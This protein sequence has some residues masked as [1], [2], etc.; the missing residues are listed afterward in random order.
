MRL[1]T[2]YVFGLVL[3]AIIIA[4]AGGLF[5]F[6]EVKN[7]SRFIVE[8]ENAQVVADLVQVGPLTAGRIKVMNVDVG[9]P[10][11]EGQAIAIVEVS[12]TITRSGTTDTEQIG[13]RGVQDLQVEVLAPISGVI[14][15]RWAKIGDIVP[16]G[17]RIVT[18]MDPRQVW[19]EANIE[20]DEIEDVRPGQTVEIEVETLER[21]LLGRV[22]SVSPVTTATL[23]TT[24]GGA[25]A[26]DFK[27]VKRV[28]QIKITIDA[29]QPPLIPGTS[30]EIKVLTP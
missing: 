5:A 6:S 1:R 27:S 9:S 3:A 7:A 22:E 30:A 26:S 2:Q 14:A 12:T 16:A 11:V 29:N 17:Q 15:A 10:V 4:V 28:I 20:E 24:T 19:I 18:L 13:F 23:S 8:T 25:S 21:K